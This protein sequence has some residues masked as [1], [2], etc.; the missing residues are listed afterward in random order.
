M[1]SRARHVWHRWP[2]FFRIV[3]GQGSIERMDL[4][5]CE[6]PSPSGNVPPAV[7]LAQAHNLTA[8]RSPD[9]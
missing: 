7:I 4:L 8:A 6:A 5:S 1:R 3:V 2:E 9:A